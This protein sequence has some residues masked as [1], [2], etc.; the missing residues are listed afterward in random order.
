MSA[1]GCS[2]DSDG[3][4][5]PHEEEHDQQSHT[6]GD[7]DPDV[8]YLSDDNLTHQPC[9]EEKGA[10]DDKIKKRPMHLIGKLHRDQWYE[11]E[12]SYGERNEEWS[13]I[14]SDHNSLAR[15]PGLIFDR[16]GVYLPNVRSGRKTPGRKEEVL[17][18]GRAEATIIPLSTSRS[19]SSSLFI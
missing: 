19:I 18:A 6:D 7:A 14:L 12:E 1:D 13:G 2:E 5:S 10:G 9:A 16:L 17:Y 3:E 4:L 11:Q 15:F 8:V